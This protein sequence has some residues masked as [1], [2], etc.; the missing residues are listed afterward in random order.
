MYNNVTNRLK[1]YQ[2]CLSV[3]NTW[4]SLDAVTHVVISLQ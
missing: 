4:C 2:W 3:I 1:Y